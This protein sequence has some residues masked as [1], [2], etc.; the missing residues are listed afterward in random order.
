[1][2]GTVLATRFLGPGLGFGLRT[3]GRLRLGAS[4]SAGD[5]EGALGARVEGLASYH[6][7]P[8][9][10]RGVSP[11]VGGGVAVEVTANESDEFLLLVLGVESSPAGRAGWF[12]DVGVGGGLRFSAGIRLRSA[13][14]R[15]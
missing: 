3:P 11:Y 14:R 6:L 7:D 13:R 2:V 4:T 15:G 12:V 5:R 9:K 1:M 8:F 10:T